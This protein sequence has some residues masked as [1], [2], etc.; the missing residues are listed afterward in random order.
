MNIIGYQVRWLEVK[1]GVHCDVVYP[2]GN[3]SY[4]K[5]E[6]REE[7]LERYA[8]FT[9]R[10]RKMYFLVITTTTVIPGALDQVEQLEA[11]K[12]VLSDEQQRIN[13]LE[14]QVRMLEEERAEYLK[15]EERA[16][17]PRDVVTLMLKGLDWLFD[18][19]NCDLHKYEEV[20]RA[21]KEAAAWL[22]RS[23]K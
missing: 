23:E 1:D 10:G 21:R 4:Y 16:W 18:H 7:A 22:D 20:L 2:L 15:P 13:N 17:P 11:A 8:D 9:R 19:Y 12:E 3:G 6:E 14:A 5:L